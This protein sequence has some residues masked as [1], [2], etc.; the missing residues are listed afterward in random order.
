MRTQANEAAYGK[1]HGRRTVVKSRTTLR[2][3]SEWEG[4]IVQT[5]IGVRNRG[6][7]LPAGTYWLVTR[8]HGGLELTSLPCRCCGF[9]LHIIKVNEREVT[10]VG[11]LAGRD[12]SA[13]KDYQARA[14]TDKWRI[15]GAE[16]AK[17]AADE[18]ATDE[19]PEKR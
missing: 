19:K 17:P 3:K 1:L 13:L 15:N 5:L 18:N 7:G 11:H 14:V 16:P 12:E 6:G 9:R 4:A 8:N 2:R 10:Y